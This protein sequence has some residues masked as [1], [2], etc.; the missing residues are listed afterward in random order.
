MNFEAL[1]IITFLGTLYGTSLVSSRFCVGQ[2][3]PLTYTG[4]RLTIAS[5]IYIL[6][7]VFRLS[8]RSFPTDLNLWKKGAVFGVI[9]D[10][11]PLA[12][13]VLALQYQSSGVTAILVSLFPAV[14][15]LI[16]H[17]FLPDEP[18]TLQKSAGLIIALGGAVLM[19]ILGETGLPDVTHANPL[20][21]LLVLA[22]ALAAAIGSIYARKNL[23]H[24]DA[25]QLTTV[26]FSSAA[27]VVLPLSL[28]VSGFDLS[29]V[30]SVGYG[31]LLYA[32]LVIFFA[33]FMGF[34]VIKRFG[35]SINAMT[36]YVTPVAA[37]LVGALV[38]GERITPGMLGGMALIASGLIMINAQ[39]T[40]K[41]ASS[42]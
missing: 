22:A 40:P 15:V 8:R 20:G 21:Y 9:G 41:L 12:L 2:F 33:F 14:T 39:R 36:D 29:R 17:F 27:L 4:L 38:L 35:V 28:L 10:A 30:T 25:W 37:T 3:A 13:I 24:Y 6:S 26:R 16:A 23:T 34:V 18:L 31:V 19:G 5:L 11:A 7:Y 42:K 1:A 32:S